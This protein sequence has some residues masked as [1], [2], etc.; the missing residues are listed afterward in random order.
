MS[1]L[2]AGFHEN[3]TVILIFVVLLLWTA[4][5]QL[6]STTARQALLLVASYLFY[7]NWG[8]SF[9]LALIA[10]SLVNYW[11]GSVLR[12]RDTPGFL[13]IGIAIN[14]VPLAF[15]KYLPHLM[16]VAAADA[17]RPDFLR[18]VIMPIG[19]SFWTFQNLSYLFD[20]YFGKEM[21][22]SLLEFCLFIAFWPTVLSGPISRVPDMLPQF[23]ARPVFSAA[24]LSAGALYL[25]QGASM[26]FLVAQLLG[27]GWRPGSG[28]NAGF[29]L[30]GG[31]GAA[32][33][34]FLGVGF[35]FQ[36]FFDFAGYSLMVIGIAR[37]FGITVAPN[38]E[39]PFLSSSP[40]VFWT[41]WH[42]SLSFW[43]RD[44]VF[45]PLASAWRRYSW[46]PY[47]VLVISMGLF[48]LWHG[49]KLTFAVYGLYHGLLLV[50]HRLG[51]QAK[52][53]VPIRLPQRVRHGLAWGTTFL[54]ITVG[55]IIFRAN[56]L[57]QAAAMIRVLVIPGEYRRFELPPSFYALVLGVSGGYFAI[58]E[59]QQL[60]LS[61]RARYR[62]ATAESRRVGVDGGL[63]DA[64]GAAV[65]AGGAVDFFATRLW[66]WMAPGLSV[67][68]VL[69]GL[70]MISREAVITVTPFIYTLF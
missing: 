48:G 67:V 32:D 16:D 58:T 18:Y 12:R 55:F 53:Q 3:Q 10:S 26:K 20:I 40:S 7:A 6:R 13:W 35:G 4:A 44:Y 24:E 30:T 70:A 54:L 45:L 23:R 22:P 62:Q 41:R 60:L 37:M 33:V 36:L 11:W 19:M 63:I 65:I 42:M 52:G 50:L 64:G 1:I 68:A 21:D 39:R 51:Q 34:W 9:L 14:L 56:D 59:I 69:A 46:W 61:W 17:S 2:L 5:W 28:V 47:V 49:P 66:W 38:F 8:V 15:F 29:E 57:A 27:S 43:I 25:V 31:W